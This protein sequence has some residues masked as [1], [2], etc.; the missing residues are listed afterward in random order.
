M[1]W[2]QTPLGFWAAERIN[3]KI[4]NLEEFRGRSPRWLLEIEPRSESV[5]SA[6]MVLDR[7][8]GLQ[9]TP[10]IVEFRPRRRA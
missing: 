9:E 8:L 1:N 7:V 10:P 2:D 6:L 5:G 4:V 3:P